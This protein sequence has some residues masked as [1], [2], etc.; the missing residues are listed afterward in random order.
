MLKKIIVAAVIVGSGA[1]VPLLYEANPDAFE[2]IVSSSPDQDAEPSGVTVA[3]VSPRE[4]VPVTGTLSGRTHAVKMD[5]QGHFRDEFKL[6]GRRITAL[7]DTGATLVA[8]NR[9]TARRIGIKLE[10]SDFKYEVNTAN[11]ITHAASATIERLQ[12]GRVE[13]ANVKAV[14][15]ED[16]ALTGTL[17]GMSFLKRLDKFKVEGRELVL[18]Q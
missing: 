3:S 7:I 18:E 1:S 17:I 2:R 11:G 12:I 14:V 13:M 8:I 6:N 9:T 4:A 15:L 5:A 10:K 16:K